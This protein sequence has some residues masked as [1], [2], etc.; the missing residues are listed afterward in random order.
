MATVDQLNASLLLDSAADGEV[1][2]AVA[3][4]PV[5]AG[6]APE[7]VVDAEAAEVVADG[8]R[9]PVPALTAVAIGLCVAVT[10]V[11]G[12]FP[13]PL[14]DLAHQATLLFVP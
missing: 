13:A 2:G 1:D 5:S 9:V 10:V 11:F 7:A 6:A 8:E 3:A 4:R 14:I 12:I